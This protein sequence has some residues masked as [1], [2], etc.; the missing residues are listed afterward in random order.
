MHT[1]EIPIFTSLIMHANLPC[2]SHHS[3]QVDT[4]AL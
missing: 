2:Q 1:T 3:M 4:T